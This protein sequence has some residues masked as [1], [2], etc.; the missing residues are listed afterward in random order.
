MFQTFKDIIIISTPIVLAIISYLTARANNKIATV[1]T[2][3]DSLEVKVDGRL[4]ELLEATT[5]A[6]R[7]EITAEQ[8]EQ[9]RLNIEAAVAR[10]IQQATPIQNHANEPIEVKVVNTPIEVIAKEIIPKKD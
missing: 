8:A 9:N 1:K 3:V 10:G 4:T 5:K 6:A 7:F 2:N